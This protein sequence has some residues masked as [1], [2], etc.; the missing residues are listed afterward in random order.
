MKNPPL[1]DIIPV[2]LL[3][4]PTLR[5]VSACGNPNSFSLPPKPSQAICDDLSGVG[6]G[7]GDLFY[8]QSLV[9]FRNVLVSVEKQLAFD[10]RLFVT[11]RFRRRFSQGN[12]SV[13]PYNSLKLLV[14]SSD[15][16]YL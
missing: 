5:F 6:W 11:H 13:P 2:H 8:M 9:D 1:T 7:M 15:Y 10:H 16:V 3:L 12:I 14:E 4:R